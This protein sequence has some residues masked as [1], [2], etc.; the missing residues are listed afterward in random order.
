MTQDHRVKEM[1]L[2]KE[3]YWTSYLLKHKEFQLSLNELQDSA[4]AHF[5]S[6]VVQHVRFC[7]GFLSTYA[8]NLKQVEE[9]VGKGESLMRIQDFN[10]RFE[11]NQRSLKVLEKEKIFGY[12]RAKMFEGNSGVVKDFEPTGPGELKVEKG[13][14]FMVRSGDFH[15]N[16]VK[17]IGGDGNKGFVP[18]V[19]VE[20]FRFG[21]VLQE[22]D[23]VY[24]ISFGNIDFKCEI[25]KH[26]ETLSG[27]IKSYTKINKPVQR[28]QH[29]IRLMS[30]IGEI[31]RANKILLHNYQEFDE[32][33]QD[34]FVFLPNYT[35]SYHFCLKVLQSSSEKLVL[36]PLIC[37]IA[38][39]IVKNK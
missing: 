10:A 15:C 16:W 2:I 7:T 11:Y 27:F 14:R 30:R 19:C 6:P 4:K 1:E 21:L 8:E 35:E 33:I 29:L 38:E 39:E 28:E 36:S 23:R 22:P 3:D 18:K 25:E 17:G 5:V 31:I 32:I 34:Y 13:D 12:V 20:V 24:K 37:A 26:L 9:S